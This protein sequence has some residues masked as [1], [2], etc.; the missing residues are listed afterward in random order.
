MSS[1]TVDP[2]SPGFHECKYFIDGI[3]VDGGINEDP[4]PDG[5]GHWFR[6]VK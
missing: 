6:C 5:D 2:G 3:L 1:S 4:A